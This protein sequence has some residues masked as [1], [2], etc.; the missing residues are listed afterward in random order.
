MMETVAKAAAATDS[1]VVTRGVV[2]VVGGCRWRRLV[3]V[4]EVGG[5]V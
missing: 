2:E 3:D 1:R 5:G 4:E